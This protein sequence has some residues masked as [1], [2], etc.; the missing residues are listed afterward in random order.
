MRPILYWLLASCQIIRRRHRSWENLQ[1][2]IKVSESVIFVEGAGAKV[3]QFE[4]ARLE[5][6]QEIF[7]LDV[8]VDDAS[9]VAS[10]DCLDHLPEEAPGQLLFKNSFL[11]DEVKEV[12]ARL[13]PLHDNDEGVMALEV[14]DES[15]NA[16]DVGDPVHEADL[17]GNL[18]QSDLQIE[19]GQRGFQRLLMF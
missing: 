12:L 15:D 11:C 2:T 4:F 3:D 17:Q 18:V 1:L 10:Q 7:V 9:P 14:V 16:G 5:V 8:S 19:K 6:D 13:G